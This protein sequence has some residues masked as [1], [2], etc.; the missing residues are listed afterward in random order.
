MLELLFGDQETERILFY[1]INNKTCYAKK[2]ADRFEIAVSG[3]QRSLA[4]L[5]KQGI[6]ISTLE[7]RIRYYQFNPRCL[8]LDDFKSFIKKSYSFLPPNLRQK[9]YEKIERTRPRR[10]GKP[11]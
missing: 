4:K 2:L 7:G 1:L 5:E 8:Y 9:Y 3:I 11:L 6:L 10:Q